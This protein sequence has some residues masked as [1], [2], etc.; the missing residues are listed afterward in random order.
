[1][2]MQIIG[3]S[4][5]QSGQDCVCRNRFY[6]ELELY[7]SMAL[8]YRL[9]IPAYIVKL[10]FFNLAQSII[11]WLAPLGRHKMKPIFVLKLGMTTCS[12]YLGK[13][14][15]DEGDGSDYHCC[16]K[17]IIGPNNARN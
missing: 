8:V 10:L 14:F 17:L 12:F 9:R 13:P 16:Q 7:S 5:S 3:A 11:N 15:L 4:K 1:M 2:Q 6:R